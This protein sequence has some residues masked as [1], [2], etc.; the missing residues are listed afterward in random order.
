MV[1]TISKTNNAY[2]LNELSELI[3]NN[4]DTNFQINIFLID[5]ESLDEYQKI[6]YINNGRIFIKRKLIEEY[7]PWDVFCKEFSHI[8]TF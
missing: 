3:S 1:V 8:G 5:N 4:R 2:W 6:G 7:L